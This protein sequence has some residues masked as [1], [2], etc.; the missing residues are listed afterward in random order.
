MTGRRSPTLSRVALVVGVLLVATL[1]ALAI[2]SRTSSSPGDGLARNQYLDPGS[3]VSGPAPDF[4][5]TDQ[6]GRPVS[7]HSY[8][9][10]IVI[11]AFNDSECTTICPL[12]TTAMVDAK[13]L[14]GAA[15]S[16]VQLLGIDA[17]P[18]ATS[19]K[20]VRSYS[21]AH[22]MLHRLALPDRIAAHA[23]AR[24]AGLPHRRRDRGGPD[25]PHAGS[26]RDRHQAGSRACI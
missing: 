3:P 17:N 26:V 21:Q 24:V 7:L 4:T 1:C 8:L 19:I 6:F 23:Q 25:R 2:I 12:T 13:E 5:L 22:G 10:R 11:L 18:N 16:K 15:G 14:L 20:D 9:G